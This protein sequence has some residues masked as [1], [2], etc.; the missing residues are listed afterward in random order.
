MSDKKT[1]IGYFEEY[2]PIRNYIRKFE[3]KHL[4]KFIRKI[5]CQTPLED[6]SGPK[7]ECF[8]I[9]I[10]S[11]SHTKIYPW[12][13][14]FLGRLIIWDWKNIRGDKQI[15]KNSFCQLVQK[16]RNLESHTSKNI[17]EIHQREGDKNTLNKILRLPLYYQPPFEIQ[18]TKCSFA[19]SIYLFRDTIKHSP[20]FARFISRTLELNEQLFYD[21]LFKIYLIFLKSKDQ[22][23]NG[24]LFEQENGII[25][26]NKFKSLF[27]EDEWMLLE[28]VLNKLSINLDKDDFVSNFNEKHPIRNYVSEYSNWSLL[29]LY[30]FLKINNTYYLWNRFCMEY[31]IE[32]GVYENLKNIDS[33]KFGDYF[34]PVFEKYMKNHIKFWHIPFKTE[35]DLK[36][37]GYEKQVDFVIENKNNL[38][39]IESKAVVSKL[40][41]SIYPS[42]ELMIQTYSKN[43]LKALYQSHI[44][45]K[46]YHTENFKFQSNIFLLIVTYQELLLGNIEDSYAEWIREGLKEKYNVIDF[47]IKPENIFVLPLDDFD[48]LLSVTEGSK[49]EMFKILEEIVQVE[50]KKSSSEKS[51]T[52]KGH[53]LKLKKDLNDKYRGNPFLKPV[54]EKYMSEMKFKLNNPHL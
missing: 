18:N 41:P 29:F 32:F 20:N 13:L 31:K 5:C 47:S 25:E 27:K 50:K 23:E 51:F 8:G 15:E 35:K 22:F 45:A 17:K 30:P 16:I 12:E 7:I 26:K 2:K 6:T 44:V 1:N 28:T 3:K 37:N 33:G 10:S 54:Y 4:I 9:Q 21:T 53:L 34:G 49:E 36:N 14:T 38:L 24:F 46:K 52:F 43:I 11:F 40:Q 48:I 42:K 19:R 39:L